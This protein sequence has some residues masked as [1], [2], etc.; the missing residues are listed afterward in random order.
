M[1]DFLSIQEFSE[2]SGIETSTLRYWDNIGLFSPVKRNKEN[3]YRYY[4][5]EQIIAVNFIKVMSSLNVPLKTIGEMQKE[6]TPAKI[7]KFIGQQQ[8]LLDMEMQ[9]LRECYS[10]IHTR[11]ELI[12]YGMRLEN[13]FNTAD[14]I[15]AIGGSQA[16]KEVWVDETGIF[17]L[18]EEDKFLILGPQNEWVEG[19]GFYEPFKKFCNQS[20]K[21]RINLNFP[22]GGLHESIEMF[23]EK[24]ECPSNFFTIDPMGNY[25]RPAGYYLTGFARGYYGDLKNLAERMKEY[26]K[27]NS[28]KTSGP[29]FTMY[30][31][32]E[33]CIK[34]PDRYLAQL[35]VA[36]SK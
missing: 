16:E 35:T 7:V 3:N 27:E 11:G 13:G 28:L 24:P 10:I 6:R 23:L 31:H 25:K 34:D 29:A 22:V 26:I 1:K 17:I 4:S 30:L 36:V 21:L 5:P 20:D 15:G 9:R 19:E 8:K 12:Q 14:G 18:Y 33:V 2:F 32:D